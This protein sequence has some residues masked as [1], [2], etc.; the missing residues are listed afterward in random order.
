[1]ELTDTMGAQQSQVEIDNVKRLTKEGA[2]S[3]KT[4]V[5][6][7][8]MDVSMLLGNSKRKGRLWSQNFDP[9]PERK[10]KEEEEENTSS[11]NGSVTKKNTKMKVHFGDFSNG[12]HSLS[13]DA[14]RQKQVHAARDSHPA[15]LVLGRLLNINIANPFLILEDLRLASDED[16]RRRDEELGHVG[17]KLIH[18]WCSSVD[19]KIPALSDDHIQD[20]I[21]FVEIQLKARNQ[22]DPLTP[23]DAALLP[24]RIRE[25]YNE[26]RGNPSKTFKTHTQ[27]PHDPD[28]IDAIIHDY[29]CV[30]YLLKPEIPNATEVEVNQEP[31]VVIEEVSDEGALQQPPVEIIITDHDEEKSGDISIQEATVIDWTTQNDD[32]ALNQAVSNTEIIDDYAHNDAVD[33]NTFD[34][35]SQGALTNDIPRTSAVDGFDEIE[36]G[37]FTKIHYAASE[38]SNTGSIQEDIR[39]SEIDSVV[40]NC[41]SMVA[42]VVMSCDPGDAS[43]IINPGEEEAMSKGI[44]S[45]QLNDVTDGVH[46]ENHQYAPID[47]DYTQSL[48]RLPI[49]VQ[50]DTMHDLDNPKNR[51]TRPKTSPME[52]YTPRYRQSGM[53]EK[54]SV[55]RYHPMQH[56]G[57][58]RNFYNT[59]DSVNPW[60]GLENLSSNSS[61]T[62]VESRV[63]PSL[64][65]KRVSASTFIYDNAV[66][67]MSIS[68]TLPIAV[69]APKKNR[70]WETL[71]KTMVMDFD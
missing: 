38:S 32:I 30:M 29:F 42:K 27:S 21:D 14:R 65:G 20:M 54:N 10:E 70:Q 50:R 31:N 59:V 58:G 67:K 66:T 69:K 63:D 13:E 34:E 22:V 2:V 48:G 61:V 15:S 24:A 71:E 40:P 3:Q 60:R 28:D 1:M 57:N 33:V 44:I 16:L 7:D 64:E 41:G 11:E 19:F 25:A 52:K 6:D 4:S 39:G 43:V 51:S 56:P 35:I 12:D 23:F 55:M 49:H 18:K 45:M 36:E 62:S 9:A 47:N 53:V 17:I 68:N 5:Q 8:V 37:Y 46:F 26:W